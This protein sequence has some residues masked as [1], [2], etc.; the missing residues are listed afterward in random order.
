[1]SVNPSRE[2]QETGHGHLGDMLYP[3]QSRKLRWQTRKYVQQALIPGQEESI[4]VKILSPNAN[5]GQ[6]EFEPCTGIFTPRL[7]VLAVIKATV[8]E[9][10]GLLP[11]EFKT[12]NREVDTTWG[13]LKP[14]HYV[15]LSVQREL[16]GLAGIS[17]EKVLVVP[18]DFPHPRG[19]I[20]FGKPFL[21]KHCGGALPKKVRQHARKQGISRH[22]I[23]LDNSHGTGRKKTGKRSVQSKRQRSPQQTVWENQEQENVGH[24][25]PS[26]KKARTSQPPT[27][28]QN[29]GWYNPNQEIIG[30]SPE[31]H[32]NATHMQPTQ[33]SAFAPME[34]QCMY[35]L[36]VPLSCR[37]KLLGSSSSLLGCWKSLNG[38]MFR[39]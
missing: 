28:T 36:T 33:S 4:A 21:Q 25:P 13:P 18:D 10:L 34:S 24:R 26:N 2:E 7:P 17:L 8:V 23:T 9:D 38:A 12:P 27:Q 6:L 32:N 1:M 19:D 14:T 35:Y 11:I 31:L 5:L 16:Y 39:F 30:Q 20:F 37:H 15:E 22:I 3:S 29:S